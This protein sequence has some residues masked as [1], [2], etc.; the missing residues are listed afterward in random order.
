MVFWALASAATA[1]RLTLGELV[2]SRSARSGRRLIAFGGLSWALDGAAAPVAAVLRLGDRME[3][4]GAL[5]PRRRDPPR[6][7]RR[8]RF[9]FATSRSR[10]R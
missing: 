4:L 8:V 7:R 1:G 10:I 6:A 5:S 3:S 9:D 2:V